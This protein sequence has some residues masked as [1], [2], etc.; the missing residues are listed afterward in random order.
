MIRGHASNRAAALKAGALQLIASTA[1]DFQSPSQSRRPG[2]QLIGDGVRGSGV[3]GLS[4]FEANAK[5]SAQDQAPA[6]ASAPP[7]P[8]PRRDAAAAGAYAAARAKA[9]VS[10]EEAE[11][12]AVNQRGGGGGG[13]EEGAAAVVGEEGEEAG[14][15]AR[16]QAAHVVPLTDNPIPSKQWCGRVIHTHTHTHAHTRTHNAAFHS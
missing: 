7:P 9:G 14:R 3:G 13:E 6:S 11:A 15:K 16:G 10:L 8:L 5:A 4:E 2:A 12:G 1:A